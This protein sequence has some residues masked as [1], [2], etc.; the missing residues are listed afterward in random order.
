MGNDDTLVQVEEEVGCLTKIGC[1][2]SGGFSQYFN[3]PVDVEAEEF[4]LWLTQRVHP[5][6]EE[7]DWIDVLLPSQLN[8]KCG[9]ESLIEDLESRARFVLGECHVAD[10]DTNP[11][12]WKSVVC[13]SM[14]EC[15]TVC[16]KLRAMALLNDAFI[17]GSMTIVCTTA[18]GS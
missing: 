8:F 7:L 10:L 18:F 14:R 1:Q 5:V 4:K 9:Y 16:E 15:W 6:A 11:L 2:P 12:R 13:V 17:G 3:A